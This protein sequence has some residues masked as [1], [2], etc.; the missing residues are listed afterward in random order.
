MKGRTKTTGVYGSQALPQCEE[1]PYKDHRGVWVTGLAPVR[2]GR[3]G[4]VVAVLGLDID[5]NRWAS[6]LAVYRWLGVS[7]TA[8]AVVAALL[9]FSCVVRTTQANAS[10]TT[11][12]DDL[13]RAEVAV[14][15]TESKWREFVTGAPIG[16]IRTTVEGQIIKA[17]P[18]LLKLSGFK[19]LQQLNE[20]G[21]VNLYE[22]PQDRQRLLKAV[23]D[24]PVTGFE[25]QFKRADGRTFTAS[26]HARLVRDGQ[27]RP[28]FVEAAVEDVTERRRAEEVQK[29]SE[30]RLSSIIS[31]LPDAAFVIDS[32]GKVIAWNQAMETMTGIKAQEMLGKGNYEYAIPFYGRRRPILI[33]LVRSSQT[34]LEREYQHL[35]RSYQVLIGEAVLRVGGRDMYLQGRARAFSGVHGEY[36]GAIE[37]LH[38][39]T[40]LKRIE[41]ALRDSEQKLRSIL[42]TTG[43]GFWMIDNETITT[44]VNDAMCA[45]LGTPREQIL[46]RSVFDFVDEENAATLREQIERRGRGERGAYE[47]TLI[48]PD[49]LRVPCIFH[50]N[51]LFGPDGRKIASFAMVTDITERKRAEEALLASEERYRTLIS[52][53]PVGL[54]RNTPWPEGRLITANPAIA[55]MFGY[56]SP[57]EFMKVRSG[58]TWVEPAKRKAFSER[59][60]A[61]GQVSGVEVHLKKRDGTL[62]WGSITAKVVRNDRGAPEFF[63]G[64]IEDITERKRAEEALRES[65]ER[66]RRVASSAQDA[67]LMIDDQGNATFWNEAAE[68]IFGYSSE[69]VLGKE[70]HALIGPERYRESYRNGFAQFRETGEGPAIGKTLELVAVRRDGT[71]FPVELSLSALKLKG[72]WVSI[73]MLRDITDRKRVEEELKLRNVLLSTQQEVS[74]DGILVVDTNGKMI[75]FNQRFVEMWRIPDEVIKSRSDE[76]ALQSVLGMLVNPEEF[77]AKVNHLYEYLAETSRDE[78]VLVD[79]RTFDRYSAPMLG[80]DGIYYG[81]V[82]YF[83]DITQNK[84]VEEELR[85]AKVS[86]EEANRAKSSF[87]ANMSHEIRTPMNAILG[88][89]QLMQRDASLSPEQKQRVNAINRSGEHLLALINDVLEMSKIEAGRTSLNPSLFDLYSLLD[90]MEMMFRVRTDAKKLSFSATRNADVPRYVVS[91]EG[92]LRQVLINLLGNAVKFTQQGGIALR[93][94]VHGR[95]NGR[96]RLVADVEDTGPGIAEE[97]HCKLFDHF[98]QTATGIRNGGGTGLGLAISREF[99]HLLGG[100]LT[101]RSQVG[102]GSVFSIEIDIEEGKETAA[103]TAAPRRRVK[104]LEPGQPTFRILIVDDKEEN[105]VVLRDM[106]G[107]VGFQIREAINGED[108]LAKFETWQPDLVVM[109][110]RMP[111][112]DGYEATRRIKS[113]ARG[114]ETP[115]LAVTASAF[116]ENKEK[117]FVA[118]ADDFLRKP[119]REHEL[120]EKIAACLGVRYV[121]EEETPTGGQREQEAPVALTAASLRAMPVEWKKEM[122]EAAVN[123]DR[124]RLFELIGQAEIPQASV[125]QSLRNLATGFRYDTLLTLLQ[126]EG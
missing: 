100:E 12:I 35:E 107:M 123:G 17:N 116:D 63:D 121:Y 93:V 83:R 55:R 124:D 70:L 95:S 51:P 43:E 9:L 85:K 72:K 50:A 11:V 120:F 61:E 79:G 106:V 89:T 69:E 64:M 71:E 113:T 38:D 98:E 2:D 1:G 99:A 39:F 46:G 30:Q 3:T 80:S 88:F 82:W 68:R 109:D 16:I 90:D 40:D 108:A 15:L 111:V 54:Y 77:I 5:A 115:V 58:D 117:V 97:E 104:G 96:L 10:L 7:L 25:T 73:G 62:F 52:N 84:H 27:G 105:R 67:I 60:L 53:L 21:L 13:L 74:I 36:I 126:G 49:G 4:A 102:V 86:A 92:K 24:G 45:T 42:E 75:S 59:L 118:G 41:Q 47:I 112:M 91:D 78:I 33:D 20:F 37:I 14:N 57:E 31:F 8:L 110:V 6:G 28:R 119:Y 103:S 23:H 65:E 76:R 34:E 114:R 44:A 94:G 81:R 22:S 122:K 66:F 125:A 101:V 32:E 26:L 56:P 18:T 29:A 48:R 87:L 19:S